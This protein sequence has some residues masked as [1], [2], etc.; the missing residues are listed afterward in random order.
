MPHEP[1]GCISSAG[2][3]HSAPTIVV[4]V[5]DVVVVDVVVV[6]VVGDVDCAVGRAGMLV[7]N[8]NVSAVSS[9]GD[10]LLMLAKSRSLRLVCTSVMFFWFIFFLALS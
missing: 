6:V 9:M 10:S 3:L 8:G 5:G 4:V 2:G 7:T 1:V